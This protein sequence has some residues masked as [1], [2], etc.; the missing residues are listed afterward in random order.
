RNYARDI[1]RSAKAHRVANRVLYI[2]DQHL[3][4]LLKHARGVVTLNSTAGLQALFHQTPVHTLGDCLYA[5]R[6]LVHE[7]P[8]DDFWKAPGKVDMNLYLRF[9]NYLV[10]NTQL[11][12]SFYG[13]AP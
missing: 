9:R 8:L 10:R 11:N 3:P 1:E 5:V 2:H 6:G 7:G 13:D 12:A 4:T